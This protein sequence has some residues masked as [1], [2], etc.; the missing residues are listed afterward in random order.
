[1]NPNSNQEI[2]LNLLNGAASNSSTSTN[3]SSGVNVSA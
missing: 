2:I 1:L 3:Q